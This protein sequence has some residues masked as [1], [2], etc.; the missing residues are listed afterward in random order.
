[1][2]SRRNR[3]GLAAAILLIG[4]AAFAAVGSDDILAELKA[5]NLSIT[6]STLDVQNVECEPTASPVAAVNEA[7]ARAGTEPTQRNA[8]LEGAV[9]ELSGKKGPV[10]TKIMT[11]QQGSRFRQSEAFDNRISYKASDGNIF[12]TLEDTGQGRQQLDIF[13]VDV[14][15]SRDLLNTET[16]GISFG[17]LLQNKAVVSR[18]DD[19]WAVN[20]QVAQDQVTTLRFDDQLRLVHLTSAKGDDVVVEKWYCGYQERGEYSVP[21]AIVTWYAGAKILR[22]TKINNIVLNEPIDERNLTVPVD[23]LRVTTVDFRSQPPIVEQKGVMV[24][25]E[26]ERLF[27]EIAVMPDSGSTGTQSG[28]PISPGSTEA[29]PTGA[30][31]VGSVGGGAAAGHSL[32]RGP[33]AVAA[34]VLIAAIALLVVLMARHRKGKG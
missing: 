32:W 29:Q 20:V 30:P 2:R 18:E 8:I 33:A 22:L 9:R 26:K 6:S 25:V 34:C 7:V 27:R 15:S 31:A 17:R 4:G 24:A 19:G 13:A 28:S 10:L 1:M 23:P 16:L 3:R 5:R 11:Y 21:G 12:A 14:Q